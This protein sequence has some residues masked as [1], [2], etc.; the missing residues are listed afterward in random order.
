[1][2]ITAQ[3]QKAIL[4]LIEQGVEA[5][6]GK[7][8]KISRTQWEI[9][10]TSMKAY[11]KP[12]DYAELNQPSQYFF[13]AYC[14]AT[15]KMFLSYFTSRSAALLTQSFLAGS[16]RGLQAT[17]QMQETAVIEVSNIVINAVAASLADRCGM[18]F[19]LSAPKSVRGARADI[20]KAA[21]GDFVATGKIFSAYIHLASKEIAAD[22]TLMLL[23]DD[24]IVN[25]ILNAI[26][27]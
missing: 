9:R 23:L 22:C 14:Q 21:F 2:E 13:G 27:P 20:L 10:T 15:G 17:P 24:L 16:R 7:L 3:D 6:A 1:M 8:A 5:S 26:E 25:F 19:I 4:Q 18:A 11:A 12:E